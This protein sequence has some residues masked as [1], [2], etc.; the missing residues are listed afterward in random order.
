M[1]LAEA[2][3]VS[4]MLLESRGL[5]VN[6]ALRDLLWLHVV[7]IEQWRRTPVPER[8]QFEGRA[9][10]VLATFWAGATASV[11]SGRRHTVKQHDNP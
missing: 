10:A 1:S 8:D 11:P 3:Q 7:L 4:S 9:D 5:A 2:Q 6:R